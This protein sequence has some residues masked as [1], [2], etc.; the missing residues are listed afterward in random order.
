MLF[1]WAHVHTYFGFEGKVSRS[2]V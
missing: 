1:S 2:I